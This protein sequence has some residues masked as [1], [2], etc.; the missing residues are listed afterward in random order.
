MKILVLSNY[1][2]PYFEGGYEISCQETVDYLLSMGN[3]V[4]I[5]TGTK[6]LASPVSSLGILQSGIAERIYRYIDYRQGGFLQKHQVEVFNYRVTKEAIKQVKPDI[7]YIWNM[8]AISIAP[9]IAV[10]H[11]KLPRLY[12]IGDFWIYTYQNPSLAGKLFRWLKAV[13]PFTIGGK[14]HIDPVLV[15]ARWMQIEISKTLG[16]KHIHVIPRGILLPPDRANK[17]RHS[18]FRLLF[19]G[20]IEP[21]KGLHLCITAL[22]QLC[23]THPDLDYELNI[24]GEE[25]QPYGAD[26]HQLVKKYHLQEKIHFMGK[27]LDTDSVFW[28]HD[29]V[30]MPTLAKEAFGR[31]IIEAMARRCPVIATA[32]YGP[33]EIISHGSDGY[34]F[35]S[36]D[37]DALAQQIELMLSLTDAEYT[38]MAAAARQ[39]VADKYELSLVKRQILDKLEYYKSAPVGSR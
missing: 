21:L 14:L 26:C 34:L 18:P 23:E 24:F 2:P 9:V 8:K 13:L 32:A 27:T 3:Q 17:S 6:G 37:V 35:P 22:H 7:V 5:L 11:S 33:A 30:L 29:A 16:S 12:D 39:T 38:M 4:Y 31:V 36:G 19:M 20:R 15:I 25:D 10:Q 28:E 1:Y